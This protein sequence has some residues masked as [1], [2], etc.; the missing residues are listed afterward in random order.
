MEA[1]F[2]T[3]GFVSRDQEDAVEL[4]IEGEGHSPLAA[5]RAEPQFLHIR[6]AGVPQRIDARTSQLRPELLK[7]AGQSQNLRPYV[8][9]QLEELQLEFIVNLNTPARLII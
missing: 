9:V 8:F 6:V 1:L 4:R 3:A 5:G 7:Q 2:T